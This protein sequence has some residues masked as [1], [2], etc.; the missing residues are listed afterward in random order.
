MPNKRAASEQVGFRIEPKL[1]HEWG[2]LVGHSLIPN[3]AHHACAL[4]LYLRASPELRHAAQKAYLQFQQQGELDR[5]SL[6][7]TIGPLTPDEEELLSAYRSATDKARDEAIANLLDR[8][9]ASSRNTGIG[10][11]RNHRAG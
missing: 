5:S 11:T 7:S 6:T 1:A 10:G 8:P 3:R 9:E 4:L 2:Q